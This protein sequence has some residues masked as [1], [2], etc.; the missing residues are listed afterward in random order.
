M[1]PVYPFPENLLTITALLRGTSPEELL[2][3]AHSLLSSSTNFFSGYLG[4]SLWTV[5]HPRPTSQRRVR[6]RIQRIQQYRTLVEQ[7][8]TNLVAAKEESDKFEEEFAALAEGVI[9]AGP[10]HSN[11]V[12]I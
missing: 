1:K 4:L 10:E 7:R 12:R 5:V 11:L 8:Q 2:S 3:S 6:R 9:D